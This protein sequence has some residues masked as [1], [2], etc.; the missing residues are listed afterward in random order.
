MVHR[1][2]AECDIPKAASE[3]FEIAL[4]RGAVCSGAAPNHTIKESIK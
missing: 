3:D 2:T 4:I 1:K